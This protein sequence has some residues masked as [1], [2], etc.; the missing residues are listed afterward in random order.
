MRTIMTMMTVETPEEKKQSSKNVLKSRILI[1]AAAIKIANNTNPRN[2]D[3]KEKN[4]TTAVALWSPANAS[5]IN[6]VNI[7]VEGAAA[8]VDQRTHP[9]RM[10]SLLCSFF[11]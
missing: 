9:E 8:A 10:G 6:T 4:I 5:A 3:V 2:A 11:Y 7:T 1:H